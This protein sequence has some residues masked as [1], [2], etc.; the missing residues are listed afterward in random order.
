MMTLAIGACGALLLLVAFAAE[1]FGRLESDSV[2]YDSLNLL[3]AG[4]LTAYAVLLGSWPFIVLEGI[5]A[6][7]AG[8]YFLK[9]LA[10]QGKTR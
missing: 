3:G 5:W 10:R 2:L 4:L 6:L 1:K 7:V 9:R 8:R